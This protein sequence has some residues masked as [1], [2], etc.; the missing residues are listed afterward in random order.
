MTNCTQTTFGF[1]SVEKRKVQCDFTG[2]DITSDGGVVLLRQADRMTGLMAAVNAAIAD[3]RDPDRVTHDQLSLLRQRV[4]ALACGYEDLNDHQDLRHDPAIQT[5]V[6]RVERL[7]SA[8]TLCRLEQR[9][10]RAAVVAMH[11]VLLDR[12]IASHRHAPKELVLD[13]DPTDDRV[14]GNQ[15]GRFFHGYYD[16]YCFLRATRGRTCT[17]QGT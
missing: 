15:E 16:H 10:D 7:G 9:V 13:F 3:P 5:A 4:Y 6:A 12:F 2:G 17:Y 11:E 1:P 8:S 14:H